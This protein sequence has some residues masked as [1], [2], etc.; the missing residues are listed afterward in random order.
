MLEPQRRCS[1]IA[2][3]SCLAKAGIL[4]EG[5]ATAEVSEGMQP[6]P[7]ISPEWGGGEG[8]GEGKRGGRRRRERGE[9]EGG[10]KKRAVQ[11]YL[12]F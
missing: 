9:G 2:E 11:Q 3:R 1:G 10:E 7:D 8:K 4:E 5:A 12:P 6:F